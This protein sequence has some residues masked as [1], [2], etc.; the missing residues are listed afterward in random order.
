MRHL[1]TR[2]MFTLVC[3]AL[4]ACTDGAAL[5]G[6]AELDRPNILEGNRYSSNTPPAWELY[7]LEK[8]P[9]EMRN[10]YGNPKYADIIAE[11][12]AQL[13]AMRGRLGETDAN[14]P[15]LEKIIEAHWND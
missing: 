1:F 14:Y 2:I 12:K 15:Q 7:D 3:C 8:D 6:P 11:L 9:H 13:L 4:I 10:E 5:A